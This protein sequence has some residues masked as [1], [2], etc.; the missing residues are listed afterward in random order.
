M[1]R[2]VTSRTAGCGPSI[3]DPN[4]IRHPPP[5]DEPA[6]SGGNLW[7]WRYCA[8]A[9][10]LTGAALL[11]VRGQDH[12]HVAAVLLGRALDDTQLGDVRR[13]PLQQPEAQLGPGLLASAEHD[14][15]LDLVAGLEE[16]H[17]VTL[18]GLVVVVVDLRPELH[19]L[20]DRQ[21]LVPAG[22]TGLLGVLVLELPVVHELDDRRAGVRGD[23]DE[24]EIDLLGQAQR[25]GDRD[26]ADLLPF[27]SDKSD[28]GNADPVV[29][30]WLD[31]D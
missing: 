20:D 11:L 19:L 7:A 30:A 23:L 27:G 25:L 28:L 8:A 4:R 26:D 22:L 6:G 13:E 1:A 16:P 12:D 3:P 9:S 5:P 14:R 2:R 18:L 10:C 17:D 29:D 24:I 21:D 15:D 31:A